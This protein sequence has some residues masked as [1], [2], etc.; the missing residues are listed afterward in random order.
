MDVERGATAVLSAPIRCEAAR[1]EPQESCSYGGVEGEKKVTVTDGYFLISAFVIKYRHLVHL[2]PHT[3]RADVRDFGSSG[4]N[5][6]GFLLACNPELIMRV[7]VV[8]LF[9]MQT[10]AKITPV[11]KL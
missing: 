8:V 3:V 7:Y 6:F 2:G 10:V 1:S 11:S 9:T 5:K 4:E